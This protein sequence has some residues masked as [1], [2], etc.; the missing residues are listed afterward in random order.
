MDISWD[1]RGVPTITAAN[2]QEV[3]HGFGQAQATA[4][5]K[6]V[7]ELY[8]IARGEAA[9][10][11]GEPFIAGDVEHARLGLTDHIDE[12]IA[13][14]ETQTMQRLQAFC[15]GF[16]AACW[17][18]SSLGA[19]RREVLP[20]TARDV[21]G[22]AV[23]VFLAF[24]R[25]W[26]DGMA[27]ARPGG[28]GLLGGGSS[29]WAVSADRSSTGEAMLLINP[30]VPWVGPY[31]MFEARSLSPGR[32]CHGIT[33]I[34]FPWQA[35]AYG[36]RAG[37]THT[38]N[39]IPQLWAYELNIVDEHYAYEGTE[40]AL[41]QREHMVTVLDQK[42]L[43][44]TERR[45][46]HGPVVTAPDGADIAIRVAGV[47][48]Q[49][50]TKSLEGW[51]QM[52]LATSVE[53]LLAA[54]DR[55]PLP[56]FNI[57]AADDSGSVAAAYC[58]V[59]P[60][61]PGGLFEDSQRRLPGHDAT[62]LWADVN[63]PDSLP[64]VINPGC[65]WVQNVNET[66][67]WFCEPPLDPENYPAGIAPPAD[68][69]RDIRSSLSRDWLRDSELVSP[70]RLL[71]LKWQTRVWM[72]DIVLDDLIA[73]ADREPDLH[74]EVAALRSWDRHAQP[75]SRGYPLFHLWAHDHL[76][77]AAPLMD[78]QHLVP[79]IHPG[80]APIGLTD[81]AAATTALRRASA[82]LTEFGHRPDASYGEVAIIAPGAD[83]PIEAIGGPSYFGIFKCLEVVPNPDRWPAI[84]GDTWIALV[85]YTQHG[86]EAAAILVNGNTTE[87][88][89]R[90]SQSQTDLFAA[91]RLQALPPFPSR[92]GDQ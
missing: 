14:Q 40:L 45:S 77:V 76:A 42:P 8:G 74:H 38:V 67:W 41:Q 83:H 78:G 35:F 66:P 29:A 55:H 34:G 28:P 37:W 1:S 44:V 81:P 57:I 46:V 4:Q 73:A 21:V 56:M 71:E 79:S 23:K 50:A 70:E 69:L 60:H 87:A 49:P 90:T 27:F 2:D 7:L 92:S 33:P 84:G 39:P 18:N 72:A 31:R 5:A 58:G 54:Q 36:P 17:Q 12:W 62:L 25:F 61:R 22:H 64:R 75:T 52:S 19:G 51:W 3:C 13:G 15:D 59:T 63:P 10:R 82:K 6:E 65:G 89:R 24:A 9:A 91:D 32:Q 85:R 53:E 80:E 30:H 47:L 68:Q 48:H 86:P 20:V 43:A 88:E 26:D 16:N 11:W